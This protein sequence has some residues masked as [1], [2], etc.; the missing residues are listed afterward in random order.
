M[1]HIEIILE[2]EKLAEQN[3]N[4]TECKRFLRKFYRLGITENVI[5]QANA[6]IKLFGNKK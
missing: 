2:A 6:I 3:P 4:N 1:E 5:E